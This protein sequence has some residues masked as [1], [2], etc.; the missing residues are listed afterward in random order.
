[1]VA[2]PHTFKKQTDC[3]EFVHQKLAV[4]R[5][6][7]VPLC[8]IRIECTGPVQ[9][10]SSIQWSWMHGTFVCGRLWSFAACLLGNCKDSNNYRV[11]GGRTSTAEDQLVATKT[12]RRAVGCASASGCSATTHGDVTDV[13]HE[14]WFSN[15]PL[16]SQLLI[17]H[18]SACQCSTAATCAVTVVGY[19]IVVETLSRGHWRSGHAG[20]SGC[21]WPLGTVLWLKR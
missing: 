7:S 21:N 16:K 12:R 1:M 8:R 20:K 18:T 2:V 19:S 5:T 11:D 4:Q 3:T 17:A 14:W 15:P 10:G 9:R 13:P 6:S